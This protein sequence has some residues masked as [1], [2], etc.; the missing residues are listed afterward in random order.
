MEV[1]SVHRRT[2]EL[3][4]PGEKKGW[5]QGAIR[6]INLNNNGLVTNSLTEN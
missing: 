6:K 3:D 1:N 5:E 2:V 4:S